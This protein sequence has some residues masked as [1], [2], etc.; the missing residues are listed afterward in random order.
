MQVMRADSVNGG[1]GGGGGGGGVGGVTIVIIL[2]L[3]SNSLHASHPLTP[4]PSPLTS[5]SLF[6]AAATARHNF[7]S[8]LLPCTLARVH[9]FLCLPPPPPPPSSTREVTSQNISAGISTSQG[10]LH[11]ETSCPP[12]QPLRTLHACAAGDFP[13]K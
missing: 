8:L 10:T 13:F 6:A 2:Q 4:H 11:P 9:A 7:R 1:G 5:S 12:P 3:L